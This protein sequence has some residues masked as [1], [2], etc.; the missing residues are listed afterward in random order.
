MSTLIIAEKPELGRAIAAAID[1]KTRESHGVIEKQNVV[2]TWAYGHLLRLCEPQEYDE[3]YGTW[4]MEDLPICFNEWK[5]VPDG[6]KK[7]RVEQ[8]RALISQCD[9]IIHAGD[10]DDEGQFLI[11]EILDYVGNT[12]PVQ[13]VY[14]NDN[15]PENIRRAFHE[16]IDN[17]PLRLIGRSAYARAVADYVV[18]INYSR[19]Y[20]LGLRMKG[21][22]VGRVQS[23]T[24]G[25]IVAR[26]EAIDGHVKTKYYELE[27][28]GKCEDA[29][30]LLRFKPNAAL[31]DEE[32]HI[33]HRDVFEEIEA[34]LLHTHHTMKV[35]E[36]AIEQRPPLPFNLAKL[37][38][39]MN[40]KYGFDLSKT[41]Q[42]TQV[43]RDRYQAI[44]Y[45]RSD[46]QYLKVEHHK[47]APQVI[48]KAMAKLNETYPVDYRIRSQCFQ[49]KFVTAHHAIIPTQS[50]FDIRKL[51]V[52]ERRVYE[53]I[54][55]FY[56]MQFLPPMKKRQLTAT[57]KLPQGELRAVSTFVLEEGYHQ[58][59]HKDVESDEGNEDGHD[60][61]D[62]KPGKYDVLMEEGMISEKETNPPKRYTQATLIRD[63][64]SIAKYVKDKEI[65]DL[66]KKKDKDKKGE[67]GSIG[68]SATRSQ[69]VD[70]LLKRGYV[71]MKG[72][73]IIST[74]LGK[75]FYHLLPPEV[76]TADLTAKWWVIQEDIKEGKADVSDLV[77][78]VL[79]NFRPHLS[80]DF[81]A[82]QKSVTYPVDDD[83]K[84][85]G[86]CPV[87]GNKIVEKEKNFG[88]VNWRNGCKFTIW[89]NDAFLSK[90]G[91]TPSR[92]MVEKLLKDGYCKVKL[93]DE[94]GVEQ[95]RVL[96]LGLRNGYAAFRLLDLPSS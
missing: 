50:D 79:E 78:S 23:P 33:L 95:I 86:I 36:K 21:L 44:T 12:K 65:K 53:E 77:N 41:D 66:L 71:E 52:D 73:Q 43:L 4:R 63:M 7:K 96:Q 27:V 68:T 9:R 83:R 69:I 2:I 75:D 22:S 25:L 70:T 89:K 92:A 49:D 32:K 82:L 56:I 54:C 3:K 14:I 19:L 13:R 39:H 46:S 1:G 64:T 28:K 48:G 67:N 34:Q 31:L 29:S 38:A 85:I 51:T 80:Q 15:T 58:Y 24:L 59:F 42:I 84:A 40:T 18:G 61:F 62:F 5:L 72:K 45:N 35:S 47:E 55:R 8:I 20:S 17:E 93:V 26:D 87:C 57:V 90:I 60:S 30:I 81:T 11:D 16:L 91:K 6:D 76:K 10:P 37:Q 94:Q 74:K 88:C